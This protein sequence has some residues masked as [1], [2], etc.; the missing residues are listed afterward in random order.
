MIAHIKG[1]WV[2]VTRGGRADGRGEVGGRRSE[3]GGRRSEVGG[4]RSEV[5]V[6]R[7]WCLVLGA[8]C[9]VLGAS[10]VVPGS[11]FVSVSASCSSLPAL[12]SS[13]FALGS[14]P[15]ALGSL[16]QLSERVRKRAVQAVTQVVGAG[17]TLAD[18]VQLAQVFC[19]TSDVRLVSLALLRLQEHLSGCGYPVLPAFGRWRSGR[20]PRPTAPLLSSR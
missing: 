12:R 2:S 8:L 7:A 10:F 1:K 5:S 16:P 15:L 9:L 13:L 19:P 14:L 3:V 6:P 20:A 11:W 18:A 17:A 4:R